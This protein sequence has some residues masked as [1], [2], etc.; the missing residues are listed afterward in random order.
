VAPRQLNQGRHRHHARYARGRPQVLV[1]SGVLAIARAR[2][3]A[4]AVH[5]TVPGVI[6]PGAERTVKNES[7]QPIHVVAACERLKVR[8]LSWARLPRTTIF[9]LTRSGTAVRPCASAIPTVR[10]QGAGTVEDISL[11][12]GAQAGARE[13]VING[14][15]LVANV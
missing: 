5:V 12:S 9:A 11:R 15:E 1:D 13:P 3:H 6:E 14:Q 2:S 10:S 4:A 7:D 8:D